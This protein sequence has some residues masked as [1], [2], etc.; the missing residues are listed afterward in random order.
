[1][2]PVRVYPSKLLL[3]EGVGSGRGDVRV[4]LLPVD[5]L[6]AGRFEALLALQERA[7]LRGDHTLAEA[8]TDRIL[9]EMTAGAV[10]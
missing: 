3:S 5:R 4:R 7:R 6:A 10:L 8:Y 1:M 2:S 9:D